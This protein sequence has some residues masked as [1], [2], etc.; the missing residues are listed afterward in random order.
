[1]RAI[2]ARKEANKSLLHKTILKPGMAAFDIT[3]IL[4]Q[5]LQAGYHTEPWASVITRL[6]PG[7]EFQRQGNI[8]A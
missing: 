1:M 4:G 8:E 6:E 3:R 5:A 2:E 7:V